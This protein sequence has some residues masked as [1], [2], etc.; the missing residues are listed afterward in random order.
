MVSEE[1]GER[2]EIEKAVRET[3]LLKDLVTVQTFRFA[4][5]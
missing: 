4:H 3:A 1:D 2:A 5:A